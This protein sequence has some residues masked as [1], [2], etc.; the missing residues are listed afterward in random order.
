MDIKVPNHKVSGGFLGDFGIPGVKF[1]GSVFPYGF[2]ILGRS[3][4][5]EDSPNPN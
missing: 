2:E 5:S 3:Y 4:G 1:L